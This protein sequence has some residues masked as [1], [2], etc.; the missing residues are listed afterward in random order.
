MH[1]QENPRRKHCARFGITVH[2]DTQHQGVGTRLMQ[3]W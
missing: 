1:L 2:P 3:E